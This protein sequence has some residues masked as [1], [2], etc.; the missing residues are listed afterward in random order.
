M[1]E[2]DQLDNAVI[3][4]PPGWQPRTRPQDKRRRHPIAD[5]LARVERAGIR[6]GCMARVTER[7]A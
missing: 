1:I 2:R 6:I 5:V 3:R 7:Q 4:I